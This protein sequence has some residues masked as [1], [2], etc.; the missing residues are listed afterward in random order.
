MVNGIILQRDL[1][2]MFVRGNA[3]WLFDFG[4]VLR[5]GKSWYVDEAVIAEVRRFSRWGELRRDLDMRYA[6]KSRRYMMPKAFSSRGIGEPKR[7]FP[8]AG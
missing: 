2:Q 7:L 5:T 4:P 3:G 8:R 6:R 1:G